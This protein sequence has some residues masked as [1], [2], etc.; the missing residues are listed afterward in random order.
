MFL[1]GIF[2]FSGLRPCWECEGVQENKQL[3]N[4]SREDPFP[5]PDILAAGIRGRSWFLFPEQRRRRIVLCIFL[6]TRHFS[7]PV[8]SSFTVCEPWGG[9]SSWS[10]LRG[11]TSEASTLCLIRSVS[12][13]LL[14]ALCPCGS[15][16]DKTR[17]W[18]AEAGL[19]HL[20][21]SVSLRVP[22]WA[23]QLGL[24][25]VSWL[26]FLVSVPFFNQVCHWS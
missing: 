1:Q 17:L 9:W 8:S 18:K 7:I 23:S 3:K 2:W 11:S 12:L 21:G 16:L 19:C 24:S 22:G 13:G 20:L 4:D 25:P 5:R 15:L 6:S 10:L 14:T 26:P